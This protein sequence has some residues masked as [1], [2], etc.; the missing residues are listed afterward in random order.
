MTL[1]IDDSF[2]RAVN[3]VLQHEGGYA[4]EQGDRGGPTRY[5]ISLRFLQSMPDGDIDKDGDIDEQDVESLTRDQAIDFYWREFWLK[6]NYGKLADWKLAAKI[7]DLSVNM[8]PSRAHRLLQQALQSLGFK[9]AADGK[10]GSAT[11]RAANSAPR[12]ALLSAVRSEAAGYYRLIAHI[13]PDQQKF[14]EGWL[15]RAYA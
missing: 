12:D 8:G 9:V 7:F 11:F 6:F 4:N 5:G 2:A 15:R 14:L 1:I 10:L 13:N 3:I